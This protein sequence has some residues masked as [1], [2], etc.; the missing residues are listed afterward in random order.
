MAR[1][2]IVKLDMKKWADSLFGQIEAEQTKRFVAYAERQMKSIG[3]AFNAWESSGN[4]IDSLC[5][6]VYHNGRPAKMDY[7][8][9][10]QATDTSELHEF[11]KEHREQVN[12]RALAERFLT[13]FKPSKKQGWEVFWA[14]LAPYWGYWE[15]GHYNVC[16][17]Q[18]VQFS[19]MAQQ[20]D[21]VKETLEPKCK[22]TFVINVPTY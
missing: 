17:K 15:Q 22:T 14:V 20:F 3:E 2:T 6:A 5:Y 19:V 13:D 7:Y 9:S 4:L 16:F 12:G 8:R 21:L 18:R 11:S 10:P 1:K